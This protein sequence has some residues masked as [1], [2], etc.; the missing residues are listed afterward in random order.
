[1]LAPAIDANLRRLAEKTGRRPFFL[2]TAK[3]RNKFELRLDD[4]LAHLR[5]LLPS[6]I[7]LELEG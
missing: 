2:V 3:R 6:L 7:H 4:F 5:E 1:M